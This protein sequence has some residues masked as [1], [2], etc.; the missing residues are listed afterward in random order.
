MVLRG[1]YDDQVL[2]DILRLIA[3]IVIKST[4]MKSVNV[5]T[6]LSYVLC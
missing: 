3:L 5:R 6:E 2:E 1:M 4:D